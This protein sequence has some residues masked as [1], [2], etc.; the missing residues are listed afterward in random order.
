MLQIPENVMQKISSDMAKGRN[1]ARFTQDGLQ[2]QKLSTK[3]SDVDFKC[4]TCVESEVNI[5][6]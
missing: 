6:F 4:A 2:L 5:Y 1:V 3:V